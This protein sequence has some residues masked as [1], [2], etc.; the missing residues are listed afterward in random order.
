MMGDL[1]VRIADP[2]EVDAVARLINLAFRVERFFLDRDRVTVSDVRERFHTGAF[3][4]AETVDGLIGAVYLELRRE[5]CY[6]GLLS[7]DPSQQR[8]GIGRQLMAAAEDYARRHG[9][10]ALE[11][12]IVNLREE[13]PVFYRRLG[14]V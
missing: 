3:L 4:V 14:Y 9:C 2:G 5:R 7:V 12:Q 6:V 10:Q 11:L 13:L 8:T 1:S